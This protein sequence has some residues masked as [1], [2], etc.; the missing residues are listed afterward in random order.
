MSSRDLGCVL[1]TAAL[2]SA[3]ALAQTPKSV[4]SGV[5]SAAQA[6]AGEELYVTA[7]ANCHGDDL[8]GRERAPAL[9]GGAFAQRWDGATLKNLF[10]RMEAMPPDNPT[11]RLSAPQNAD[12]LAFLLSAN[13][14]PAGTEP[15]GVDKNA[16]AGIT[17][18]SQRP[19][20]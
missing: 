6:A 20:F 4:W 10:E 11:A 18:T 15:L 16:L 12:V 17:Y 5:Y 3:A 2:L 7:C 13:N 14:V 8:E 1:A 19:K 9:A